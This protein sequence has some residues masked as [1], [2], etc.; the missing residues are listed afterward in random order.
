[1]NNVL[2]TGATGFIGF[3]LV[4]ELIARGYRVKCLVRQRSDRSKLASLGVEFVIGDLS[5]RDSL[6]KAISEADAVLNLAGTT[7]ALRAADFTAANV[8][9]PRLIAACCAER[10]RPPVLVHVSSLAAAGPSQ[11]GHARVETDP[12]APISNYGKSKLAGELALYEW[13]GNVPISIVRPPIVLGP[14]D[15][16]GF[17]MFK[18][19]HDWS[20]HLV[21]SLTDHQFSIID[22]NDLSRAIVDVAE[23]GKRLRAEDDQCQGIYFISDPQVPSYAE[24][25]RM[26]GRSLGKERVRVVRCPGVALW[27]VAAF[28][29][30]A[31]RI[32]RHPHILSLDKAREANA[33]SWA[34]SSHRLCDELGFHFDRDLQS[35]LDDTAQ[36]YLD[37]RW[38]KRR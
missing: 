11:I 14:G 20:T 16:D 3:H 10:A 27:G 19:I 34:C 24:L 22:A 5:D 17:E 36:W 37:Q 13:V 30:L 12:V 25:G 31:A 8:T 33:G 4:S 28:A 26:I 21:P 2:V 29:E 15:R 1:M 7:K 23:R 38:L 18:G 9:G 32:R 35:K 6:C